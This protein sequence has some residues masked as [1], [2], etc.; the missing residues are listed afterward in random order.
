MDPAVERPQEPVPLGPFVPAEQEAR[1]PRDDR[2]RDDERRQHG[3]HHRDRQRAD[4]AARA[5]GQE[6]Q[7][8]E[9]E[10]EGRRRAQD[11]DPDLLGREDRRLR[12]RVPGAPVAGDVLDHHDRI[13][14][15][16]AERDHHP[17]DRQL[18]E[19]EAGPGERRH[20]H[21]ERQ[22]NR[23]HD[24]ERRAAAKRQQG[25]E[26]KAECDEEVLAQPPEAMGN[27]RRLIEPAVQR[28]T[29]RQ[30]PLELIEPRVDA[31]AHGADGCA[32]PL[33]RGDEDGAPA[34]EPC[35]VCR[36]GRSPADVSH[37]AHVHQPAVAAADHGAAHLVE[38]FVAARRPHA[39]AA[40]SHVHA[41]ARDV[42]AFAADRAQ[43]LADREPQRGKAAEI[44]IDVH[45][46]FRRAPALRRANAGQGRQPVLERL[47][48]RI[49]RG[50][51]RE[52]RHKRDLYDVH[53][54][55]ARL[56]DVE[57]RHLGR[58]ASA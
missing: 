13:V 17:H 19:S 51:R 21:R 4:V 28:D 43:H 8:H 14:D 49:E 45:L 40:A 32:R 48:Q 39:E 16:E 5:A 22:R 37:V 58:Q 56:V 6:E 18:V 9:R 3:E 35:P 30:C 23:D 47:A 24:H 38:R 55:R 7:R 15:Q 2:E 26:H 53:V 29:G 42:G 10:D 12:A 11:R 33:R 52:R 54:E 36:V 20:R 1:E 41:A 27:V 46:A 57:P 31:V 25:Q 34:V 44:E 50:V